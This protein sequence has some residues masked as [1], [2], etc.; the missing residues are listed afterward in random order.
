[1]PAAGAPDVW[2]VLGRC[3]G[4]TPVASS[5]AVLSPVAPKPTLTRW[6]TAK[7]RARR[8]LRDT[9]SA[10]FWLYVVLQLLVVDVFSLIFGA[11]AS[12]ARFV[13]THRAIPVAILCLILGAFYW[14]WKT[15]WSLLYV[16]FFPLIVVCWKVPKLFVKARLY[17]NAMAMM[18]L[19]NGGML[20]AKNVRYHLISKSA[21]LIAVVLIALSDSPTLI[22]L[23]A[24]IVLILLA[25]SLVRV[26]LQTFRSG[27]FVE[28]QG[29]LLSFAA[30]VTDSP[31]QLNVVTGADGTVTKQQAEQLAN[32]IQAAAIFNRLLYLWAYKLQQYRE[33]SFV[34]VFNALAYAALFVGSTVALF[35]LNLAVL[36]AA[37]GQYAGPAHP[38]TIA[39]YL[40]SLSSMFF[41]D[42]GGISPS[43][44][45]AFGV[46]IFAELFGPGFALTVIVN[47]LLVRSGSRDDTDLKKTVKELT[48]RAQQ[49]EANFHE[50]TRVGVDEAC[51][52]LVKLGLGNLI[53]FL[54][55]LKEAVPSEFIGGDSGK[56]E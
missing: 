36:R 46:R 14:R 34:V 20:L 51:Q 38:S 43:G 54:N 42:G 12:S 39:L 18:A 48:R 1:M 31:I 26:V 53:S 13:V 21:G 32:S 50:A 29:K 49:H 37:P 10:G 24:G 28:S 47:T 11:D 6:Q 9:I 52:R 27:A 19:L 23:G 41:S 35:L 33:A 55:W 22:L 5:Q 17:R 7:L 44:N 30:K 56:A 45:I 15:L 16:A 25:C 4:I 8:V 3:S 2:L 40:Y